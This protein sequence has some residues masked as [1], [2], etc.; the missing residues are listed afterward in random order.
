[1]IESFRYPRRGLGMM[2]DAAARRT[3][4]LGGDVRLGRQVEK[5]VFDAATGLWTVT[6]RGAGGERETYRATRVISSAAIRDLAGMIEPPPASWSQAAQLRYRN[7]I[8]V[9]LF[10]RSRA[11]LTDHWIYIHDP[12]MK[13]GRIQNYRIWSPDMTPDPAVFSLGLE[14]FCFAGDG[15]WMS[16][17]SALIALATRELAQVGL[18]DA[19]QVV[20]GPVIR[21]PNAYPVYD[22]HYGAHVGAVRDEFA[23]RYPSLHLVGRNGM[24]K[25]NNQD[26]AMMTAMRRGKISWPVP[27]ATISGA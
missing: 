20:D 21:Q 27:A 26:H 2:W 5:L 14:Y 10:V 17:D 19:S 15:I 22:E 12:S 13:V 9:A 18:A 25:Y 3:R 24:H 7:F 16:D 11:M 8:T 1:L 23:A 6:A 4:E